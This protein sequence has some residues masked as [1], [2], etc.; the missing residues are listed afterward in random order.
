MHLATSLKNRS[1]SVALKSASFVAPIFGYILFIGLA[2][3][4][5]QVGVRIE[6]QRVEPVHDALLDGV[7]GRCPDSGLDL[8]MERAELVLDLLL[9]LAADI[10]P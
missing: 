9:S 7:G 10:P 4:R 6:F 2:A 3:I 1:A 5:G 8:V